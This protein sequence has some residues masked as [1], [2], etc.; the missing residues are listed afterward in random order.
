MAAATIGLLSPGQETIR[1]ELM[2]IL[3]QVLKALFLPPFVWIA[4]LLL[5]VACWKKRW[6]RRVALAT[7]IL[8]VLLHSGLAARTTVYILES[9]FPP[10]ID[11]HKVVPYDA[12]VL[13]TGGSI[14][15][16]GRIPFPSVSQATFRRL[17][18]A[19]RLYR[20]A[21]RPII[22]S[23][24]H[25]DPFTPPA[26]ENKIVCDY[27]RLWGVPADD[28]IPE[29]RSRDTFESAVEVKRIL[30]S[31]GWRRYLLVTSASHMPRS[32]LAFTTVAPEPIPA[33][34]DFL[35]G[36]IGFSPLGVMP[37]EQAAGNV[38]LA[39]HE[40]IGLANYWWRSRSY[41]QD[42]SAQ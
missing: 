1:L 13:L 18:E 29:A 21:P 27:L 26:G 39:I 11:P 7:L 28:I 5:T 16:T 10:L 42:H 36:R 24:G 9:R 19:W 23:G 25:V 4:L 3:K 32:M 40:Y 33:P 17:E 41:P 2:F 38:Y 20:M 22:V 15:A 12:I 8:I 14:P 6:A 37:T 35:V 30:A 34:G 31:K